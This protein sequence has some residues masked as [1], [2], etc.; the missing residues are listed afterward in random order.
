[1]TSLA[2]DTVVAPFDPRCEDRPSGKLLSSQRGLPKHR[3]LNRTVAG[4]RHPNEGS[5]KLVGRPADQTFLLIIGADRQVRREACP[6]APLPFGLFG[7]NGRV[8]RS[9]RGRAAGGSS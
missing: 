4:A 9:G 5:D 6:C 7:R 1:M 8:R 2:T 3:R